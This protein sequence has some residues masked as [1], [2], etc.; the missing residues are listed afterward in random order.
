MHNN[1]G[2]SDDGDDADDINSLAD[3]RDLAFRQKPESLKKAKGFKKSKNNNQQVKALS[4]SSNDSSDGYSDE[5]F[6]AMEASF[7]DDAPSS[8]SGLSSKVRQIIKQGGQVSRIS[9]SRGCWRCQ[10]IPCSTRYWTITTQGCSA[11]GPSAISTTCAYLT[12]SAS[13]SS[14]LVRSQ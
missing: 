2:E 9:S 13:R 10:R 6:C 7:D 12:R 4:V 8:F 1:C 11:P 14:K 3:F 5:Y